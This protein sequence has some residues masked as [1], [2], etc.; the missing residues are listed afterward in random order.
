MDNAA[1]QTMNTYR[2][3]LTGVT[4]ASCVKSIEQ[5]LRSIPG[6]QDAQVNFPER[7]AMVTANRTITFDVLVN[8]IKHAGYGATPINDIEHEEQIKAVIERDYYHHLIYKT[9][10]AA[11]VGIP[12]FVVGTFNWM[13]SLIT[14]T[15]FIINLLLCFIT[16]CVLVYSGGHFFIGAWKAFRLHT[17]NMDTLIALGTGVAWFYSLIALLFTAWLPSLAQHVYFEAATIIIALVNFGALLELRARRHTSSAIKRLMG[18][19]PKTAR[20]V[21]G[22]EEIDV[23]IETL[24]IGDMIRVRPGEKIPVDGVLTEG[25]SNVDESMLTGE[26]LPVT[27]NIR[28]SVVSGTVNKTG[29]FIFKASHVGKDTVLAKIIQLV[30][31]AQNSKPK[32]AKLADQI[33]S[34]FVPTV[35][36]IAI[37]TALIWFNVGP[38]PKSAYMLVTA[39]AVLVIACPCALGLAVPISVIIGVGKAAEYGILIRQADAL[40]QA[41]TLTTIVLD[42]TGTIT[43]G[44]P[45]LIGIYP[46]PGQDEIELLTL[47]ASLEA[48][49][50]HSLADAILS[51]AKEKK[52]NLLNVTNFQASAGRGV[53][54]VIQ[55]KTVCLGNSIF[56]Q[57][58]KIKLDDILQQSEQLAKEGKTPIFVAIDNEVIGVLAIA[59]P[60]KPD[61][62]SA[63]SR[64]KKMGIK[65]IML[66]GDHHATA[67]AIASEVD[68]DN[69]IA[70]VLPQDKAIKITELQVNGEI[71][72]MVGD[73]INDAPALARAH[74]GFAIGT[75]TDIAIESAGI[76]L[77]RGS[78][79]GIADAITISQQTI[80]NMKQNLFG[81]FIYNVVGIPIAAGILFPFIGLLLNPMI[82]GA[83]MALSSVTVVSNA[84]R[85]RFFNPKDK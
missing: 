85:L 28:D 13:P 70:E 20:L 82:A 62:K 32:L 73:G 18:L 42:K 69:V 84:N 56:M 59:D 36:I 35:M 79:E 23:P 24:I 46:I 50:E 58:L 34:V 43:L 12:L 53:S 64:L 21:K 66:T 60:I 72:G 17:A 41:G 1:K 2:F 3:A 71:V 52:L 83:A 29:T 68:I 67:K 33:S 31:Q 30:Q 19:Q 76:T 39:M 74:V 9:A 57:Q 10:F 48:G 7:T 40:Q 27:K 15:G 51:A 55:E 77:M 16:L 26:P 5:A 14:S 54:G 6:V 25:S 37:V 38:E 44:Q 63:I 81:A 22:E 65:V 11:L 78:L 4:C 49:S 80:R 61:A 47:A 8:A 45:K 75:G